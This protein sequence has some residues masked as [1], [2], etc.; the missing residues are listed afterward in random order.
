MAA[1]TEWFFDDELSRL[2]W[3]WVAALREYGRG[4]RASTLQ[5]VH[6]A[7]EAYVTR[8]GRLR[9]RAN[10]PGSTEIATSRSARSQT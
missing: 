7:Q 9:S 4:S 2:R 3:Q 10:S 5:Q 1:E 6:A 8:A